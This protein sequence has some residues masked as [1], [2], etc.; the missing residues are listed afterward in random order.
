MKIYKGYV[1]RLYPNEY[2]K[3]IIN[4]SFGVSR[5]IY[6]HFLEEKQREYKDTKKSKSAYEQIKEIPLYTTIHRSHL[7]KKNLFV[8]YNI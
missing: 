4:K 7:Q 5:F 1:F 8:I 6:N 2:Q 3:E